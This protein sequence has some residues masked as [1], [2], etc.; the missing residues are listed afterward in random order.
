MCICNSR[1]VKEALYN[2]R[3][4]RDIF[5]GLSVRAIL[6][7]LHIWDLV[8]RMTLSD[9]PDAFLWNWTGDAQQSTLSAYSFGRCQRQTIAN[10]LC[11]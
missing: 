6:D 10:S 11:G 9:M 1:T 5:G 8:E 4:V 7:Y 3:W 2:H